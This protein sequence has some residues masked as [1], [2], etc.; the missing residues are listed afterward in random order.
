VG[1]RTEVRLSPG[2]YHSFT[3]RI[4]S[5]GD[6]GELTHGEVVH[7]ATRR[8]LHFRDLRTLLHFMLGSLKTPAEL[9]AVRVDDPIE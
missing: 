6:T 3:V 9:D 8:S 5:R 7:V 2:R 1:Q 4:W